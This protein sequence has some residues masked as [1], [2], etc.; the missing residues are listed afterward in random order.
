[1]PNDKKHYCF[2]CGNVTE[3]KEELPNGET[4]YVC[5]KRS[6]IKEFSLREQEIEIEEREAHEAEKYSRY[7]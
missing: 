5:D 3:E 1:M 4:L 6:C 7:Y 2:N